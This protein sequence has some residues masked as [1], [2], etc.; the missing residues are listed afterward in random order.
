MQIFEGE[1]KEGHGVCMM[2]PIVSSLCVCVCVCVQ[3]FGG[4]DKDGHCVHDVSNCVVSCVCMCVCDV[5]K[6]LGARTK[7]DIVCACLQ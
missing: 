3:I 4:E 1:D 2:S 6:S 7:M 5:F